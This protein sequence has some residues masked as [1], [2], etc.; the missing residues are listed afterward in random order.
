[1][2]AESVCAE[3]VRTRPPHGSEPS[4]ER[5]VIPSR[6]QPGRHDPGISTTGAVCTPVKGSTTARAHALLLSDSRPRSACLFFSV[7]FFPSTA[8]AT[9]SRYVDNGLRL[10]ID[11][12]V[13]YHPRS[14]CL[15][16]F[17]FACFRFPDRWRARLPPAQCVSLLFL[18]V[19]FLR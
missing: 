9:R 1:M 13:D 19:S 5:H 4:L 6:P 10:L 2:C 18:L 7:S 3:E 16:R 11:E 12:G 14:A 17:R 15:C 8:E